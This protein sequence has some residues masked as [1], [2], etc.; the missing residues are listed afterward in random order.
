VLSDIHVLV[1]SAALTWSMLL[2]ASLL[3]SRVW[4]IPGIH[5]AFG[6]RESMPD[7]TPL[8]GRSDRAAKNMLENLALFTAL[9]VAV[10]FAGHDSASASPGA[11]LFFWARVAYWPVYLVG[12]PYLRTAI[13]TVSVV[14]LGMLG[15]AAL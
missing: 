13:W 14:G 3:R 9:V 7:S 11:S 2:T 10:R 5:V 1:L 15:A 8:T 4:T 12:I 6:N